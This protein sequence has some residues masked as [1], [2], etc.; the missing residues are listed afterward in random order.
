MLFDFYLFNTI[1][2]TFWYIFTILFVLYKFTS[3]FTYVI[4]FVNFCKDLWINLIWI[5]TKITDYILY[6]RG[7]IRINEDEHLL[8]ASRTE[9]QPLQ[10]AIPIE[11]PL[12]EI[13]IRSSSLPT[14][15]KTPFDVPNSNLLLESHFIN[16]NLKRS[17]YDSDSSTDT[18]AN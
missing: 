18:T 5:Q 11:I 12:N 9:H 14:P 8:P 13:S 16:A 17:F 4:N 6:K 1:I 3:F 15:K 10:A 2:N 7:Y